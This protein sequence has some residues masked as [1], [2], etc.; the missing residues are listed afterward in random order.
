MFRLAPGRSGSSGRDRVLHV[1]RRPVGKRRVG[2]ALVAAS[3]A[4]LVTVA[5]TAAGGVVPRG[6]ALSLAI[7]LCASVGTLFSGI[8]P[9]SAGNRALTLVAAMA[10][11]QLVG[12]LALTITD[13]HHGGPAFTSQMIAAHA[14]AAVLLGVAI[15]AVEHLTAVA[16]SILC[17]LRLVLNR[18]PQ[19]VPRPIIFWAKG[20]AARAV[21]RCQG[22]GMRA[23][24]RP[25]AG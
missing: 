22:L 10:V 7:L 5:H 23:P 1:S 20:I 15:A 25:V 9:T 17:W 24:P 13:H 6:G 11:T 14:A 8:R 12:H 4:A 16:G 18:S 3:S 19:P 2:G 21:L